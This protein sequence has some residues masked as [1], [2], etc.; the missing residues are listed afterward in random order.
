MMGETSVSEDVQQ[1]GV[2]AAKRAPGLWMVAALLVAHQVVLTIVHYVAGPALGWSPTS[3]A[4]TTT[5]IVLAAL[6]IG[7]L[8]LVDLRKADRAPAVLI[9]LPTWDARTLRFILL[10][11]VIAQIPLMI[12]ALKGATVWQAGSPSS[13]S[14]GRV[15]QAALGTPAGLAL[16]FAAV[17]V[18]PLI[19]E[20]LYRG[21]L[22]GALI[23]QMPGFIAGFISTC[24]FVTLHFEPANLVAAFC[25]GIGTS[26]CALR[27]RSIV[28]GLLVHGASN[29]FGLWYATLL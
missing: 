12:L 16:I 15:L 17:I 19:E 21:Y 1:P 6:V 9:R 18:G 4:L 28:P 5:T 11:I 24:V 22:L 7:G 27:T 13:I 23:G 29:A 14:V 20:V 2:G 26:F 3:P 10:G 25:L 8:V